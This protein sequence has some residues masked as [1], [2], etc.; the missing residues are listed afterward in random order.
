M[1]VSVHIR[2]PVWLW[3]DAAGCAPS[4]S[5]ASSKLNLGLTLCPADVAVPGLFDSLPP[6][7]HYSY[8]TPPWGL[9]FSLSTLQE[10]KERNGFFVLFVTRLRP[11]AVQAPPHPLTL[12]SGV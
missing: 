8:S 7:L 6:P 11:A 3:R 12:P 4:A 9:I 10:R 5:Q 1:C 2:I